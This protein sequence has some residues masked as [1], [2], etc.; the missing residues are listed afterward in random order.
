MLLTLMGLAAYDAG[1]SGRISMARVFISW[2]GERSKAVAQALRQ[3]IPTVL[4]SFDEAFMSH[5]DIKA[6]ARWAQVLDAALEKNDLGIVC[7]TRENLSEPW[8]LFEA[9]AIAKAADRS[10]VIPLLLDIKPADV[11]GPLSFFQSVTAD[12]EGITQLLKTLNG[13]LPKPLSDTQ[14]ESVFKRSWPE[15][16]AMLT[17]VTER[18][19][20]P[21]Q[22][23]R[24]S[25]EML[26]EVVE[27]VREIRTN[28]M[29]MAGIAPLEI[30]DHTDPTRPHRVVSMD[31]LSALAARL[32]ESHGFSEVERIHKEL[33][34]LCDLIN[35][36]RTPVRHR[37][38]TLA[39]KLLVEAEDR[40]AS[41]VGG[42]AAR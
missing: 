5:E 37:L 28:L 15:L 39:R 12:E 26:Q 7:L 32:N 29:S 2:S 31:V 38:S 13:H 24:K 23:L 20:L 27:A 30:Y 21:P 41:L 10:R 16:R 33:I 42:K 18:A 40:M 22:K 36:S 3:W 4:Q 9:G 14:L 8:L 35:E 17:A 25:E 19:A 11:T 34:E 6:G 1:Y